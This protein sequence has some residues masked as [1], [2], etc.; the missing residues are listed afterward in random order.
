MAIDLAGDIV[1]VTIAWSYPDAQVLENNLCYLCKTSGGTDSRGLLG[2]A[3]YDIFVTNWL[4]RI[5][6]AAAIYGYKVDTI[7]RVPHPLPATS[8]GIAPGSGTNPNCPTQTRPMLRLTTALAGRK[9]R[10]RLFLPSPQAADVSNSGFPVAGNTVA[11]GALGTALLAPIIVA[12]T[13][14]QLGI[15]HRVKANP[16]ATTITDVTG[17]SAPGL[18]GTQWKSGNTGRA[19]TPP[20]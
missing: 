6:P 2:V 3:V 20:W 17:N 4:P 8:I 18:F 15:C 19:N 10:G 1:R 9:F 7:N 12:G 16:A 14:W 5:G 13:T 11:V